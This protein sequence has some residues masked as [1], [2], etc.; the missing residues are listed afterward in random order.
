MARMRH[1]RLN[2]INSPMSRR[3]KQKE[4]PRSEPVRNQPVK[5]DKDHGDELQHVRVDRS[6]DG[7]KATKP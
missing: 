6:R 3:T 5:Q 2:R 4:K 1:P 7:E